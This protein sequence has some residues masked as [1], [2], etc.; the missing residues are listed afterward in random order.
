[1]IPYHPDDY[2]LWR[3]MEKNADAD[4]N[5]PLLLIIFAIA[6]VVLLT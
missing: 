4:P 3:E 2:R 5:D 1:M 6:V